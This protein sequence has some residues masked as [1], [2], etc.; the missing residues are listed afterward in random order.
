VNYDTPTVYY[1]VATHK[2]YGDS[3]KYALQTLV[4]S[5][6]NIL[7][8]AYPYFSFYLKN[9]KDDNRERRELIASNCIPTSARKPLCEIREGES[10]Q[11]NQFNKSVTRKVVVNPDYAIGE[12]GVDHFFGEHM[13]GYMSRGDYVKLTHIKRM[14]NQASVVYPCLNEYRINQILS[15]ESPVIQYQ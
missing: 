15:G 3:R 1:M 13:H 5:V 10:R 14:L 4:Y 6:A 7:C 9:E 2:V 8:D 12:R 11:L